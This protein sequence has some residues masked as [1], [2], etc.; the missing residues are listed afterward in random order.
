MFSIST[1]FLLK[2]YRGKSE[3]GLYDINFKNFAGD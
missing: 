3:L 1:L 2:I